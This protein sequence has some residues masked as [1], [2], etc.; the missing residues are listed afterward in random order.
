MNKSFLLSVAFFTLL[1]S[2]AGAEGPRASYIDGVLHTLLGL[3][4]LIAMIAV[5]LLSSQIGARDV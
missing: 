1:P 3:D 2:F 5:G 4:H